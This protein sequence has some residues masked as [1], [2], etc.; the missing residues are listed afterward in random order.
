MDDDEDGR[1]NEVVYH[2]RPN[3]LTQLVP[4]ET[5]VLTSDSIGEEEHMPSTVSS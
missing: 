2:L 3:M 1:A 5:L 4:I